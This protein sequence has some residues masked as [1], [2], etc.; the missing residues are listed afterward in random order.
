MQKIPPFAQT[1]KDGAQ[2]GEMLRFACHG[3]RAQHDNS[4][5]L[6]HGKRVPPFGQTARDGAHG[7]TSVAQAANPRL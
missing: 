5:Q 2:A 3:G 7:Q 6:S 1:A 4:V